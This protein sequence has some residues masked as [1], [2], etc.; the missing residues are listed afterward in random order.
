LQ[1]RRLPV[2]TIGWSCP[3]PARRSAAGVV[4]SCAV[5]PEH[6][7]QQR[8]VLLLEGI[9]DVLQEQQAEADMLVLGGVH[10]AA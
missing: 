8:G 5:G 7:G 10:A 4:H 3:V 2:L 1:H 9:E 6:F